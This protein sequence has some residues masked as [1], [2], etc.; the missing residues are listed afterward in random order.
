MAVTI[1]E[2]R[3]IVSKEAIA[4]WLNPSEDSIYS[5]FL[6]S[7]MQKAVDRIHQAIDSQ[8]LITVYG[9]YDA[10]GITSTTILVETLEVMGANVNYHIPNRF[11]EGYGPNQAS[12]QNLID[13]GTQL[14]ITVDNGV[15]GKETVEFLNDQNIDIIITD[16]HNLPQELPNALAIIH[17]RLNEQSY[18]FDDLAGVGVSFKLCCALLDETAYELLDLVAVGTIADMVSVTGENHALLK[19]GIDAL[20]NTQR[21]GLRQLLS[22]AGANL[23]DLDETSIGFVI[24]PRL[25][26]L[27]RLANADKAV[28]LLLSDNPK[29][30]ESLAKEIEKVNVDRKE[31]V[32]NT[33]KEALTLAKSSQYQNQKTL[34]IYQEHWHEGILG[35]V[36][37]KI[38]EETQKPAILLTKSQNGV[39]KGSGR[40]VQGFDLFAALTPIKSELVSFGGH[41]MACGLSVKETY[42]T[43]LIQKFEESFSLKS[44]DNEQLFDCCLTPDE[45]TLD[46]LEE[47]SVFGPFG[48]DF[49]TPLFKIDLPNISFA[50]KIGQTQD[51]LKFTMI[52]SKGMQ[53]AGIGFNYPHVDL[54]LFK[55]KGILYG[56]LS[57][58][59]WQGKVTPQLMLKYLDFEKERIIDCR[60]YQFQQ[61]MTVQGVYG[62][63]N[64]SKRQVF[65]EKLQLND[66]QTQLLRPNKGLPQTLIVMDQPLNNQQLE[67]IFSQSTVEQVYFYSQIKNLNLAQIP[68]QNVFREVLKYFYQHNN[69]KT[70]DLTQVASFFNLSIYELNLIL[71]VFLELNFVKI[72]RV[73]IKP[74]ENVQ[75][76]ELTSSRL[77]QQTQKQLQFVNQINAMSSLDLKRHILQYLD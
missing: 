18:P 22:E 17:P 27:G 69:L 67:A 16:H 9:D 37:N 61:I 8:E 34:I 26:S 58:N 7:D 23:A 24:S 48:T 70:T 1:L 30:C 20:K 51:H 2:N 21:L 38:V 42:L 39:L 54:N 25:N 44:E 11:T 73:L 57:K 56:E 64:E 68:N 62:F 50:R 5:P 74:V 14:F 46:K 3:G 66:S 29:I 63:F 35:I 53:V 55:E 47:I 32:V 59:E 10:D 19:F 28:E 6:F 76:K 4:D 71:R 65:K 33:T 49:E 36:A 77:L 60:H 75:S 40:S 72:D 43:N 12:Y 41:N 52:N 15:S 13:Q 45:L 31:L